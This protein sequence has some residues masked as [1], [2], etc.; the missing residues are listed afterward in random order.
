MK[1]TI[2]ENP[3]SKT[4]VTITNDEA[5]NKLDDCLAQFATDEEKYTAEGLEGVDAIEALVAEYGVERISD[6]WFS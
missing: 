3:W 4:E 6:I 1:T 2:L 5:M